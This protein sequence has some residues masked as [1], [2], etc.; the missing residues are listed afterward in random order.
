V[1]LRGQAALRSRVPE[2]EIA[3]CP[4]AAALAAAIRMSATASATAAARALVGT[5]WAAELLALLDS[6]LA[7][8]VATP[9]VG[10]S[11]ISWL[12]LIASPRTPEGTKQLPDH[13]GLRHHDRHNTAF[14]TTRL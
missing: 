6:T 12:M 13:T 5:M 14:S 7:P 11:R 9:F 8:R 2:P 4:P 3:A 10:H 1:F